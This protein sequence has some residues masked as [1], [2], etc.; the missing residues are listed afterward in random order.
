M[1]NHRENVEKRIKG[2]LES[3]AEVTDTVSSHSVVNRN[4][5]KQRPKTAAR[6]SRCGVEQGKE[7]AFILISGRRARYNE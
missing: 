2:Q 3:P 7:T 1:G 6:C 4:G 5:W